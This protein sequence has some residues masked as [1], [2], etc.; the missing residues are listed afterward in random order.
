MAAFYWMTHV[1]GASTPAELRGYGIEVYEAPEVPSDR[2]VVNLVNGVVVDFAEEGEMPATGFYADFDEILSLAE[3]RGAPLGE[4][5][6]ALRP[7]QPKAV[8]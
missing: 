2:R 5:S 1:F 3:Q 6:G 8:S 4:Q 7:L